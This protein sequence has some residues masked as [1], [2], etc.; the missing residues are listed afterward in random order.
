MN[1]LAGYLLLFL[2][3][4]LLFIGAALFIGRLF[5]PN[6]PGDQKAEPYEC[7]EQPVGSAWVQFDLRFYVVALLFVIF[8]V[9]LLFLFPWAEVFGKSVAIS[10]TPVPQSAVEYRNLANRVLEL[11]TSTLDNQYG[12]RDAPPQRSER[13]WRELQQLD[14]EQFEQLAEQPKKRRQYEAL[15]ESTLEEAGHLAWLAMIELYIFFGILLV[16]F[17]Y[18]WRRGDLKWVR[19]LKAEEQTQT[20]TAAS[21]S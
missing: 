16:G 21:P 14:D 19:S 1:N 10:Q 20:S 18:L 12:T 13:R 15:V 17:A 11:G 4:G 3:I 5:R 8:D 9:E 6:R 2:L 7:G